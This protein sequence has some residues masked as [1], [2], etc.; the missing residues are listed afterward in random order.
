M[1]RRNQKIGPLF[2]RER[3]VDSEFTYQNFRKNRYHILPKLS[4]KLER[5]EN[6]ISTKPEILKVFKSSKFIKKL[7]LGQLEIRNRSLYLSAFLHIVKL[8]PTISF[9]SI[10]D[11]KTSKSHYKGTVT[12]LPKYLKHLK[13]FHYQIDLEKPLYHKGLASHK[14]I[15][16]ATDFLRYAQNLEEVKVAFPSIQ[17]CIPDLDGLWRFESLPKSIKRLVFCNANYSERTWNTSFAHLKNL[18]N[19]EMLQTNDMIMAN[20]ATCKLLLDINCQLEALT[21]YFVEDFKI[22][23]SVCNAI[24]RLT[25]LKKVKFQV[26]LV[27]HSGNLNKILE[28]LEDCPLKDLNLKVTF[29]SDQDMDLITNFLIKKN[30]LE[31]L[32]LRLVK[33]KLEAPKNIIKLVEVIENLSKLKSL[34]VS[35]QAHHSLAKRTQILPERNLLFKKL[36]SK[37]IP[38]KKFRLILYQPGVT[39][40]GFLT[41]LKALQTSCATLEK[42]QIDIGG[43]G[44]DNKEKIKTALEFI[45]RLINIRS[46]KL[47]SLNM[48]SEW[49]LLGLIEAIKSLKYLRTLYIGEMSL[50]IGLV[51]MLNGCEKIFSKYGLQKFMFS[52]S[53]DLERSLYWKS[54]ELPLISLK[55]IGRKNPSLREGPPAPI[56]SVESADSW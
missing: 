15:K 55:K 49:V 25:K 21:I 35:A 51:E 11:V 38:L 8:T 22:D 14:K 56:Y 31:T 12:I 30:D 36:F 18:K 44:T 43:F 46:L 53:F 47:E 6:Q 37:E 27:K 34:L 19:L 3:L 33:E 42:V 32:K 45:S 23:D 50:E 26:S 1:E 13:S 52:Y 17:G 4:L 2:S 16:F 40:K 9:L 10:Y 41:L 5:E 20:E 29:K 24:K 28:S 39:E 54:E 7:D 48:I